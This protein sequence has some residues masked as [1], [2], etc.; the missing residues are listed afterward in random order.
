M[1][2]RRFFGDIGTPLDYFTVIMHLLSNK[3]SESQAKLNVPV[4]YYISTI[5][6]YI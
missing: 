5:E 6:Y 2:Y 4:G 1:E 3:P